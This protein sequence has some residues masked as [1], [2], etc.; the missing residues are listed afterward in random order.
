MRWR[1]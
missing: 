1:P